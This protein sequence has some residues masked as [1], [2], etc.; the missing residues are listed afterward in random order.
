MKNIIAEIKIKPSILFMVFISSMF[1][2]PV[3]FAA[4][5]QIVEGIEYQLVKPAQPTS[6]AEGQVEVL[7][8]FWYG[9]P[10]CYH[11]EPVLE[12]WLKNKP[13]N[14]K[15]VRLPAVMNPG[16][17]VHAR[18]YYVA[19]LLGLLD[20]IHKPFFDA[21]QKNRAAMSSPGNIA[22]FFENYGISKEKFLK[23]YRSFAVNTRI[24]R[25]RKQAKRYGAT[26]VPTIIINGKYRS[27]ATIA[28]GSH[29]HLIAVMNYLV[30]K[31]SKKTAR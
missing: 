6:V 26:S 5:S 2:Q 24:A 23:V 21:V 29:K 3:V 4:D 14:V 25:S 8:L 18:A 13:G 15:F 9:C 22:S 20:K 30:Q 12:K 31:E 10:H 28:G 7:E 11:F 17:E 1:V 27:N 16:W 19:E